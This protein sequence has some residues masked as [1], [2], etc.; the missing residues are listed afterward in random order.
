MNGLFDKMA[1]FQVF[2]CLLRQPSLLD[3]YVL[4]PEDFNGE[5]F[6]QII[7]ASIFNLYNKGVKVRNSFLHM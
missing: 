4:T 7:F 1:V 6:H 3:L 5:D 2:G